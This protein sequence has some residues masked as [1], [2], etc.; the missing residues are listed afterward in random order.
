MNSGFLCVGIKLW[1]CWI[2]L[3]IEWFYIVLPIERDFFH[4]W[5]VWDVLAFQNSCDFYT[6]T[7]SWN[8]LSHVNF[9][10][11]QT[12]QQFY[13]PSSFI[14]G[15]WRHLS[16]TYTGSLNDAHRKGH[17]FLEDAEARIHQYIY[18]LDAKSEFPNHKIVRYI[19]V[20]WK[21][22][23]HLKNKIIHWI[24]RANWATSWC[25]IVS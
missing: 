25:I 2:S 14:P 11:I 10:S 5:V 1:F 7:E 15:S 17:T 3:Y 23:V 12:A 4:D 24:R 13:T 19:I 9:L 21:Y 18:F 20:T 16:W 22:W 6:P 8:T